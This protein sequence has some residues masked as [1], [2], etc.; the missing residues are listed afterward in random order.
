MGR[1]RDSGAEPVDVHVGSRIRERRTLLGL[2]QGVLAT[3]SG[4]TF[5]QVQ[6]YENGSNRVSASKL[7]AISVALDV[8]VGWFFEGYGDGG[9]GGSD[10]RMVRRETLELARNYY[11]IRDDRVRASVY[12]HVKALAE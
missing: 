6:K 12:A 5:Q 4:V 2:S 1:P 9:A 10:D 3:A 11:G 7:W 8:P